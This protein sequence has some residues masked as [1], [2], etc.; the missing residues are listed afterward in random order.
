VLYCGG[1]SVFVDV[2]ASFGVYIAAK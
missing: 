2:M 1:G